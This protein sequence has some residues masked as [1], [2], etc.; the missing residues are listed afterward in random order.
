MARIFKK[1]LITSLSLM[2]FLGLSPIWLAQF[3]YERVFLRNS[4]ASFSMMEVFAETFYTVQEGVN[5]LLSGAEVVQEE[6]Q[7]LTEQQKQSIAKAAQIEFDPEL[8][9]EFHF[10]IGKSK[11][12]VVGYAVEDF[13]KG[14][15]GNIHYMVGLNPE[16][17]VTD[18]VVLKLQERRGRPVKEKRFLGQFMGKGKHDPVMLKRDIKGVAGAT[19]SSRGM[20][21]GIR[22]ILSIFNEFYSR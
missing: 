1:G 10:Y 21:N 5:V 19:I 7:I 18:V 16:G 22:K 4:K 12:E 3:V 20:T 13:V 2:L 15:W 11:G 14:K 9:K 17:K 6:T 8:D